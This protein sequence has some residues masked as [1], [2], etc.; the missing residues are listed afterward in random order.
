MADTL[1]S[2][3]EFSKDAL[4]RLANYHCEAIAVWEKDKRS[5]DWNKIFTV[6]PEAAV[7]V[8]S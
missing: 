7:D 1:S 6:Q 8:G 3:H 4:Q 5:G 2:P